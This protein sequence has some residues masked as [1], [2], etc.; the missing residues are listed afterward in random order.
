MSTV[1]TSFECRRW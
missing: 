1:Y